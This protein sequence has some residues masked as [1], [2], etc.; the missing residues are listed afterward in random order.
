MKL[1]YNAVKNAAIDSIEIITINQLIAVLRIFP[2]QI[3]PTTKA[4]ID[5]NN[6]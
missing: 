5:A 1:R 3:I 6:D 2:C 4:E